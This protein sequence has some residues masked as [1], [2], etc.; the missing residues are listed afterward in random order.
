MERYTRLSFWNGV[1]ERALSTAAQTFLALVGASSLFGEVDWITVASAVGMAA[2]L[3]VVKAFIVPNQ[4]DT[5]VAT[6]PYSPKHSMEV[7]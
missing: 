5:A 7:E 1:A 4:T 6:F 2:L 3:S